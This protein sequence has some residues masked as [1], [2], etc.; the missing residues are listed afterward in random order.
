MARFK[1]GDKLLHPLYGAGTVVAIEEQRD[2]GT[3]REYYVI[4]LVRGTGRLL[5]PV[6]RAEEV[7]LRKPI[8]KKDRAKLLKIL[9][10]TPTRLQEDYPKRRKKIKDTLREGSFVEIGQAVRDLAWRKSEGDATMG[11]RR[12][13]KRAKE[14]LAEELAASDGV[15]RDEAMERIEGV[16]ERKVSAWE[17]K[18]R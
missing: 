17:E 18:S 6:D 10:G 16:I 12:L 2:N 14:V 13:L 5:T 11:D 1:T 8:S 3:V 4:E 9:S 7:G 15:A